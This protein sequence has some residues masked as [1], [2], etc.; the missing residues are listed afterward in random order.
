MNGYVVGLGSWFI[1]NTL[2]V[3][4][5]VIALLMSLVA[6]GM[7]LLATLTLFIPRQCSALVARVA[8]WVSIWL[9]HSARRVA[10]KRWEWLGDGLALEVGLGPD[11]CGLRHLRMGAGKKGTSRTVNSQLIWWTVGRFFVSVMKIQKRTSIEKK[12]RVEQNELGGC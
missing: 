11:G 9:R 2:G 4:K 5:L 6:L 3:G 10:L 1:G 12:R 7:L 8:I